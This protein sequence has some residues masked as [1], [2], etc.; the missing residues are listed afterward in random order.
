MAEIDGHGGALK[1]VGWGIIG[2]GGITR[3][4]M[5]D[6]VARADGG[7][8][9]AIASTDEAR[10]AENARL[11]GAQRYYGN[12]QALLDDP[13]IDAVYIA[14]PNHLHLPLTR[15]AALAG[16]H[17]LCEKPMASTA[18]EAEQMV[19][20]CQRAGVLLMEAAMYRFHPRLI[21]LRR[22]L[23][24][25]FLGRLGLA[26]ASFCFPMPE[27]DNYRWHSAYGGGALLDVGYYC[28]GSLRWLVG[29]EPEVLW[30][31][32]S[33]HNR[34]DVDL[35]TVATLMFAGGLVGQIQCSFGT[36]EHQALELIGDRGSIR[37]DRPFT[38]WRQDPTELNW[39]EQGT[40]RETF[41]ACD[42]YQLMVESF[43]R[44]VIQA[45]PLAVPGSD[46]LANLRV[47]DAIRD[48]AQRPR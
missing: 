17:V 34:F 2:V 38:A 44:S 3:R 12:Y 24:D 41:E 14:L 1:S 32:S 28:V 29:S 4:A 21:R 31:M 26:H 37:L 48:G 22:L 16:K 30:A 6:A 40:H 46:S 9:V 27:A 19:E 47:L 42:P 7:D 10:A 23:A 15:A 35:T 13:G 20:I 36:S 33:G 18:G 45:A 5:G 39:V 25:G 43:S 8:L 11:F